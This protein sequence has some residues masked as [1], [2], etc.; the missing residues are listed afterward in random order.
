MSHFGVEI[1]IFR[2]ILYHSPTWTEQIETDEF[3]ETTV[4]IQVKGRW[5]VEFGAPAGLS[6]LA[7]Y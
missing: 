1:A 5:C 3:D 7:P 2:L 4:D 6:P